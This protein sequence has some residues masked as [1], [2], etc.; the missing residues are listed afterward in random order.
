MLSARSEITVS[1]QAIEQRDSSLVADTSSGLREVVPEIQEVPVTSPSLD[2][3][4]HMKKTYRL[5]DLVSDGGT[6]GSGRLSP[7][8]LDYNP[9]IVI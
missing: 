9:L 5:L 8:Q 7:I 2:L 6:G 1:A 4:D 3:L